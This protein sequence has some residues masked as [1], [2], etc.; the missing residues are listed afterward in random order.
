M[1]GG[2]MKLEPF[3][4]EGS[5]LGVVPPSPSHVS[6]QSD[7]KSVENTVERAFANH[8]VM[9]IRLSGVT[10]GRKH[11]SDFVWQRRAFSPCPCS[12]R[13]MPMRGW[14][15][16]LRQSEELSL[17]VQCNVRRSPHSYCT[18]TIHVTVEFL[19]LKKTLVALLHEGAIHTIMLCKACV[20]PSPAGTLHTT[21]G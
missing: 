1:A 9:Q 12:L 19:Q 2:N 5:R 3:S 16:R 18:C 7:R 13:D 6:Q 14:G 15:P 20:Q 11:D 8:S 17:V 4:A 10:P 21:V